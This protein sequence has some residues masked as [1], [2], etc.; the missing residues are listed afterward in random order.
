VQVL[1]RHH[2]PLVEGIDYALHV[3]RMPIGGIY[4]VDHRASPI[5]SKRVLLGACVIIVL[6]AGRHGDCNA[7]ACDTLRGCLV[8]AGFV[9]ILGAARRCCS[10]EDGKELHGGRCL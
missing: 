6:I 10:H 4:S 5:Y 1:D 9:G 7:S 8:S 3:G 2:Q